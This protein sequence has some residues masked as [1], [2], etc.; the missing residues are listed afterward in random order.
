[1]LRCHMNRKITVIIHIVDGRCPS[2]DSSP[3]SLRA[4]SRDGREPTRDAQVRATMVKWWQFIFSTLQCQTS[5]IFP[6]LSV[7]LEKFPG[8]CS[9]P[10]SVPGHLK[11]KVKLKTK[12]NAKV[13]TLSL[14]IKVKVETITLNMQPKWE[15]LLTVTCST[16]KWIYVH[17]KG[18]Y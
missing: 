4:T 16:Q 3:L 2:L 15:V 8:K 5:H 14:K 10:I 17:L 7:T 9:V 12:T 11:I 1:M 13:G 18:F 6:V